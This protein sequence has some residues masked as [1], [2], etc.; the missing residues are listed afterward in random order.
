MYQ[1]G[2]EMLTMTYL[3][4]IRLLLLATVLL[5]FASPSVA[6]DIVEEAKLTASDGKPFGSSASISGNTAV[7]GASSDDD[8]GDRAGAAYVFR[9]DGTAWVEEAKLHA[10]DGALLE[11]FGASVAISGD[12]IVVGA[13]F[14][15][16]L[17]VESGSAYVF[18]FD[19]TAWVEEAKL[20]ASDGAAFDLFG[21]SVSVSRDTVVVG[22]N[23]DDD[24]G[25]DSGAAYM[26]RFDGTAWVE[27]A[28]LTP[29]DG[30]ARDHFGGSVSVAGDMVAIG[31]ILDD[32]IAVD[33]GSAYVFRFDGTAW[34]EEAKLTASD[35]ASGDDFG[36]PVSAYDDTVVVGARDDEDNGSESGS[37]YVFRFDGTDWAEEVK[38]T[39]SDAAA[40]DNFGSTLSVSGDTV[41]IGASGNDDNGDRSGS[42]YVFQYTRSGWSEE[43]KFTASDVARNDHFGRS[44]SVSGD[45]IV[46]GGGS[47][48]YVF[49]LEP[50]LVEIDIE[51]NSDTNSIKLMSLDFIPV[52][53]F[54]SDNFDVLDV[55]VATLTFGPAGAEGAA[56]AHI[57]GGHYQD[58]DHDG[59]TDLLSHYRTHETGIALGHT[60]ACVMG[61]TLDGIPFDDCDKILVQSRHEP[62]FTPA[63]PDVLEIAKLT[64]FDA[65]EG[66]H[67]GNSV[68]VSGDTL[69]V[70]A[71]SDDGIGAN[72]GS[73]N[74][75][76]Y[77]GSSW[78]EEAKLTA[79][80]AAAND[81]FGYSVSVSGDTIVVGAHGND[82]DGL[83]LG[84]AYVFRFDGSVWVEEAKLTASD[85]E[86]HDR[87]G[88]SVSVFG[89][90]AVIGARRDDGY[91]EFCAPYE[92]VPNVYC[93]DPTVQNF[94]SAYVFRYDGS[95]WVEEAKLTAFDS[96]ADDEFGYS[97][98]LAG[99]T[100][101]VGA[102][103]DD[104]AGSRS[105]SAYVFRYDGSIWVDEAKL[106]ASDD[107]AG[108][109]FGYSVSVS[110]DTAIVGAT[111][112]DFK[113]RG[114]GAAYVFRY[115]GSG[116][117][118]EAKLT[119]H[120][121]WAGDKFGYSVS[122][123]GDTVVAGA[124]RHRQRQASASGFAY[125]FRYDGNG[126][127]ED[128]KLTPSDGA[129]SDEF[130]I[131][132]SV[133]GETFVVGAE[134]D[135]DGG[136]GSGS[137]YVFNLEPE[138]VDID[139]RPGNDVNPINLMG[140]GVI[141]VA[142]LGSDTFDVLDVDVEALAFGPTGTVGAAPAHNS[143]GQLA[144]LNGDGFTD[145]L[146]H[147]RT[148]ETG[149]T[150]GDTEACVMGR[151]LDGMLFEGCD[152]IL[153]LKACG[154]GFELALVVPGLM[155]L[156]QKRRVR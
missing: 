110:G 125:V 94:G 5:V 131:S 7:I 88:N 16:D 91:S 54:G 147:Y 32:N 86:E 15:N 73:A 53:I 102:R 59:F 49:Q 35:G 33:S 136:N 116:W 36:I 144:D 46:I 155:W 98:S 44:A 39:A 87:F 108:D 19:G 121:G 25:A 117:V 134:L 50:E 62:V 95:G 146:S 142:I 24:N 27:E 75:Y 3:C 90:A 156:R 122:V 133:S 143:G 41:I 132:V 66:D 84:S 30:A 154:L 92:D 61:E 17:G 89:N 145:L 42:A 120:D 107:A 104:D 76:R 72:S 119:A 80:D 79:S 115:D 6:V 51:P 52:A 140:R 38:L 10:S 126:W 40:V 47:S 103:Y 1:S 151:K 118:E 65:A 21:T 12:T 149:I 93:F 18:R 63:V 101:V 123:S 152:A 114:A 109:R 81:E 60:R 45:T 78:V 4:S 69:V 153:V 55:D 129:P 138:V 96:A 67:L 31:A 99:D 135:D 71:Y 85:G 70:G 83:S 26:F 130:G 97:V 127:L 64:A 113:G 14:D 8:L 137:A 82:T 37:A 148:Q 48:V 13:H 57:Q 106:T 9:F 23:F 112:D 28:K 29:S 77:D 34:I 11:F 139:I 100:V 141:P 56:P 150:A 22:A 58:V 20:T 111:N 43:A 68:S 74:V 128:A 105:G 2:L 124:P